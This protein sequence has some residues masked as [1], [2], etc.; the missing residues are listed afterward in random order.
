MCGPPKPMSPAGG[1]LA[2]GG[3]AGRVAD[4]VAGLAL[5]RLDFARGGIRPGPPA[6]A[7]LQV[8]APGPVELLLR[9]VDV[10]V[11][12]ADGRRELALRPLDHANAGLRGGNLDHVALRRGVA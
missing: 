6:V 1:R 2:V 10:A 5:H 12:P 3:D 11:R 9:D 8:L 4:Q 7:Q